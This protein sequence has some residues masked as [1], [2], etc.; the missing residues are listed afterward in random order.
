MTNIAEQLKDPETRENTLQV[1]RKNLASRRWRLDNLYWIV[2]EDGEVV[3]FKLN[4]AQK[5][6]FLGLWYFNI[7]LKSRQHGIT[8]FAC[9][10]FLDHCLFNSNITAGIIAHNKEDA[11]EFFSRCVKFPYDNLPHEIKKVRTAIQDSARKLSFSNGSSLI[12]TTSGRSG[13]FQLL[14]VSELGKIAAHYPEKAR[15]IKTGSLNA[16]HPGNIIIIESTSEGGEGMFYDYCKIAQDLQRK[17]AHLTPMDP[18]FFFF[19]WPD[20]RLNRLDPEGVVYLDYQVEYFKKIETEIRRTLTPQQKAWFVKKWNLM[21]DDMKREHP[22]TPQEAFEAAIEGAYYATQFIQIRKDKRIT[23]VPF[24][25]GFLVDTWWDLGIGEEDS[26]A[27]WFTQDIGRE[28]HVIRYYE[29]VN[30]GLPHYKAKLEEYQKKYNYR[31]GKFNAPHDIRAREW[32]TGKSRVNSAKDL[33]IKFAIGPKLRISS[34]IEQVRRI[35]GICIFDEAGCSQKLGNHTVGISS[36]EHYRKEWNEKLGA[37]RNEPLHDWASHGA[38][39]F[40]TLGVL[41][42]FV[43]LS[44]ALISEAKSLGGPVSISRSGHGHNSN[45]DD[46]WGAHT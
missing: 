10:L 5:I 18:K 44:A 38:D 41:H 27:I 14:H 40:R 46:I 6:L 2:N 26:T 39:A 30:E 16:I 15:E 28:I 43:P 37:Y 19:G 31:Y 45:A 29:N 36:L 22:S 1:L 12:V 3:Q 25:N 20:N 23:S 24:Q 7:I 8:T 32:G 13:V 34:G 9:I 17:K 33:G 21:G 42:K 11:Q 4:L 35:L